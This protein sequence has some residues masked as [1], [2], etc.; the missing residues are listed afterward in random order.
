MSDYAPSLDMDMDR[1]DPDPDHPDL[2]VG[3]EADGPEESGGRLEEIAVVAS[4]SA[5]QPAP[6]L[7]EA[8]DSS[9]E[10]AAAAAPA[11]ARASASA[12]RLAQTLEAAEL[13]PRL[14]LPELEARSAST[15]ARP[16]V[17]T[18]VRERSRSPDPD[19]RPRPRPPRPSVPATSLF[20]ESTVFCGDG[21][22]TIPIILRDAD[23]KASWI[24]G[25]LGML[26]VGS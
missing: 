11:R 5:Q 12:G 13:E 18:D 17:D 15:L 2:S 8:S 22:A 16:S 25:N 21:A 3:P 26:A 6:R 23:K 10:A 20:N 1:M 24:L 14:E 4:A 9:D 7:E 19:R